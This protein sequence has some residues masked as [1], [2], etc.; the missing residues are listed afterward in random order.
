MRKLFTSLFLLLVAVTVSAQQLPNYG[1]N[2]WKTSC[3]NTDATG[4]MRQR[5]GVEPSDWNGSSVNQKVSFVTKSQALIFN[6][7]G[8]VKMQSVWVGAVGIG[9]VAPGY[10]TLGT[11]WVFASTT[12][13]DCDGGTYGGVS[14][15]NKPD[16]I[17]GRFKRTD[18]N[19]EN[20]YIVA[21]L[22][23][24]TFKSNIGKKSSPNQS[25]DNVDRAILGMTS[26][27]SSGTLVAKCNYA[28]KSTGG[29]WQTITVPIEYLNN[30]TPSMMNVVIS[31]GDYWSRGNLKENTTLLADDIKFL[32][33]SELAS[34][35]YDGIEC[36][37]SN[38]IYNIND[39]Y[40]PSRISMTSNGKGATIEK[41][42]DSSSNVLTVTVKGNDFAS[43]SSNY[44][45][46]LVN[47]VGGEEGPVVGPDENEQEMLGEKLMSLADADPDKAYVLYNEHFTAYAIF[48]AAKPR[49]VWTAGMRGDATH[50]LADASYSTKVDLN[51]PYSCW[52]VKKTGD[53]YS[54]CNVGTGVYL[55]VP[56]FDAANNAVY[57]CVFSEEEVLMAAQ[58]LGDGKFAFTVTG[59]EYDYLCAA[60]Q[61]GV[62]PLSTWQSSDAGAA[63]QLIENPN[64][65]PNDVEPTP[66]PIDYLPA[67]TGA[68]TNIT[69]YVGSLSVNNQRFELTYDQR[70]QAYLDVAGEKTFVVA[71][72]KEVSFQATGDNNGWMHAYV[73]IDTDKNGFEAAIAEDGYTPTGD[74]V[75]YS[76]Y[77]N[78]AESDD[79]GWNS[80]GDKYVGDARST[81]DLPNFVAPDVPGAYRMRFKFDWCNID[82]N[83]DQDGKFGDF[84]EH[85]GQIIDMTLLVRSVVLDNTTVTLVEGATMAL[86]AS[87]IPA[88]EETESIEW[89]TSDAAVAT[90]DE[91]GLVTAISAGTATITA[92]A[93]ELTATCE[94][95]VES[96]FV[97]V[98][99]IVLG[100][101]TATLVEGETMT[102]VATVTPDEATEK[103]VTWTT[104]DENVATVDV[105]G[106]VT[107]VSAGV[108][109]ITAKAGDVEATCEVTVERAFVAVEEIVLGQATATLVE[110]ETMTLVATVTP[111][112][113]TEKSVTWTTSDEAV[114]T[115]DEA[116]VVTAVSAGVAT[117]TAKAGDVEATCEVTVERAFVAVEE[118]TLDQ[119]AATLVEG[120][121]IT[122]VATVTPDEATDKSVTWTT[123]DEAVATVDEEGVVTAISAGVATITAKA[124]D[125]EAT[126]EVTVESAFV[127]VEEITLDQ[128]A[129]TLVE[130]EA[131]TLVA[132]VTPDEATDKS[133]TWTTSDEAVAT[134]DEE[135][136]VT[137]ISAGVAI[138]TA[139]AGDVEA[140]CEVTVESAEPEVEELVLV[141]YTPSDTVEYLSYI[142]LQFNH[143]V[144]YG[145]KIASLQLR[146]GLKEVADIVG[147]DIDPVDETKVTIY[148]GEEITAS[149]SYV[150]YIPEGAF[151][152]KGTDASIATTVKLIVKESVSTGIDAAGE[153]EDVVIYDLAGRKILKTER[154]GIYIINGKKVIVK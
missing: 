26:P 54:L 116:G 142:D 95:T 147:V 53:R 94:V 82:P 9:S 146:K 123:S 84:M 138:I 58:D 62:S 12:L 22:W 34:L 143:E 117:I 139:K 20:S 88:D 126:C 98:E 59:G 72:G 69:K 60:P 23:N 55:D 74:L 77:N 5:P 28:F 106:V 153:N 29:D 10:I 136:V 145:P 15:S 6:E 36:Y 70:N 32:Y 49:Y 38:G 64:V 108:A 66:V 101:A 110:G 4:E 47:F 129:A 21:Y 42:Y 14:F 61:S 43:N 57:S 96:A 135:G 93:G 71:G 100:Q 76:F 48:N 39:S 152:A 151:Y 124:G 119:T 154:A 120:E 16:A 105:A 130:G 107:A 79:E 67:F 35:R 2:N 18:S 73:Y 115:V 103:S 40:D 52:T 3:G 7:G 50:S 33:Y 99:E 41:S 46:Y 113:A 148:L 133:V 8:A 44:H 83:G 19:D 104:S 25:R 141:A 149:G 122:L 131:I 75:S 51:S 118:I 85:G 132:T 13:S 128:T 37:G 68:K 56:A 137:A 97:A 91:S 31:G 45:E 11:P 90:V 112:D 30:G 127:A 81:L 125:V 63:W 78:G 114:A 111:D 89:S 65:S 150:L 121:T 134:V 1:F 140:T 86:N 92:K 102:L 109:T 144:E 17:T 80:V 24:G 27:A 87:V